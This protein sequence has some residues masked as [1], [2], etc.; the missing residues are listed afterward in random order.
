MRMHANLLA[1]Q[2]ECAQ[3][4]LVGSICRGAEFRTQVV[5]WRAGKNVT[6]ANTH[7]LG[8]KVHT[9]KSYVQSACVQI[10]T[11]KG[12][13]EPRWIQVLMSLAEHAHGG[14]Q[15]CM[16]MY[17]LM[18]TSISTCCV[19]L[20]LCKCRQTSAHGSVR[21]CYHGHCEHPKRVQA[22]TFVSRAQQQNEKTPRCSQERQ[23]QSIWWTPYDRPRKRCAPAHTYRCTLRNTHSRAHKHARAHPFTVTRTVTHTAALAQRKLYCSTAHL[24]DAQCA[25]HALQWQ[26]V[27]RCGL[28]LAA[29]V[30]AYGLA[31]DVDDRRAA[32]SPFGSG[33]GLQVDCEQSTCTRGPS[34]CTRGPSICK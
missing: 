9:R 28:V 27:C 33:C 25:H 7:L 3:H 11:E 2:L 32:G 10:R 15:M 22:S 12:W 20:C 34:I 13:C 4:I 26:V 14:M 31:M 21:G 24:D 17:I 8:F 23:I 5:G 29:R 18:S 19:C 30:E 16:H 1:S 6:R